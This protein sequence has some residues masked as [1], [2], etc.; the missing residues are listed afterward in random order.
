MV[1]LL[2]Q[3][4]FRVCSVMPMIEIPIVFDHSMQVIDKLTFLFIT[5]I[6]RAALTQ[7]IWGQVQ[8]LHREADKV[9]DF[10]A[11]C[12]IVT[13][14]S[15]EAEHKQWCSHVH[16]KLFEGISVSLAF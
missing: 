12:Y 6:L 7:N 8:A 11:E 2:G 15:I 4:V 10:F 5:V 14:E 1:P 16:L 3:A 9:V 13:L